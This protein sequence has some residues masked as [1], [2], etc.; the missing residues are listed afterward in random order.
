MSDPALTDCPACNKVALKR[1]ISAA[2]FRFKGGG[3]YETDFK[4]E[5]KPFSKINQINYFDGF[6]AF[7]PK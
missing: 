7:N 2:G 1:L 5:N 3:W 6:G 4:K